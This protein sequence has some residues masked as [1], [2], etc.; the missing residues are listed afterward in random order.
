M[1]HPRWLIDEAGV[2][3]SLEELCRAVVTEE[4]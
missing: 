2:G 4:P 3:S 1:Q